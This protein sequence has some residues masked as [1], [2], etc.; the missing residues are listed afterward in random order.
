[1]SRL[2]QHIAMVRNKFTLSIF[3]RTLAL[4]GMYF[5]GL[6][7]FVI[8]IEH[9]FNKTLPHHG[10]LLMIGAGVTAGV[11]LAFA[12]WKRP[13]MKATAVAID[14]TLGLKEKYSTA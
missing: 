5:V 1:M 8:G 3:L 9:R 13:T 11:A 10:L 12:L 2:D 6:I 7:C 14:E 4:V